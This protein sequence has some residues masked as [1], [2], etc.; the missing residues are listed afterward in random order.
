VC[1]VGHIAGRCAALPSNIKL[2][3]KA[4]IALYYTANWLSRPVHRHV[5]A[6]RTFKLLRTGGGARPIHG[7]NSNSNS[8]SN[9]ATN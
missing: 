2:R 6:A 3:K 7:R 1:N 9:Q 8:N 4:E 5:H